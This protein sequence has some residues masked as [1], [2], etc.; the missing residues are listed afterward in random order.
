VVKPKFGHGYIARRCL[1]FSASHS[2]IGPVESVLYG[3]VRVFLSPS[4]E[5][6]R[7]A[8]KDEELVLVVIVTYFT[9]EAALLTTVNNLRRLGL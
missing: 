7:V 9:V 3:K 2:H 6:I 4:S 5:C 1:D 8:T